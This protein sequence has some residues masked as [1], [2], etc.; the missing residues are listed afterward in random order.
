LFVAALV[1]VW[2]SMTAHSVC[3]HGDHDSDEHGGGGCA[4]TVCESSC[5]C[6]AAVVPAV[7]ETAVES[8]PAQVPPPAYQIRPGT[9]VPADI[10]RPPLE[11]A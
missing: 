11:T 8:V 2:F 1:A 4:T 9:Q 3:C 10:F 5:A 6:H 7:Q